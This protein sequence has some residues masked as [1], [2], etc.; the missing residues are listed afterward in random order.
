MEDF[1]VGLIIVAIAIGSL[2]TA[3]Y[4]WIVLGVGLMVIGVLPR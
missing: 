3:A 1:V 4:G 2:T